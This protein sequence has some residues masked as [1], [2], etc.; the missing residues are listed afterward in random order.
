[1]L[2]T[3]TGKIICPQCEVAQDVLAYTPLKQ[4][5]PNDTNPIIK[6]RNCRHVFSPKMGEVPQK[7]S[8][9]DIFGK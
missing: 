9:I 3:D 4:L 6:C 1:M 7:E 8:E 2:I 5:N